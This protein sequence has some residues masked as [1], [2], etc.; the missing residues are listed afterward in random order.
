VCFDWCVRRVAVVQKYRANQKISLFFHF[1]MQ[2]A[3]TPTSVPPSKTSSS[4]FERLKRTTV[5]APK[6]SKPPKITGVL[7]YI[8]AYCIQYLVQDV[9][10]DSKKMLVQIVDL[11]KLIVDLI[12]NNLKDFVEID[13]HG[14]PSG[15]FVPRYMVISKD[16]KTPVSGSCD[17]IREGS[18]FVIQISKDFQ[19]NVL[20][21][22]AFRI[23]NVRSEGTDLKGYFLKGGTASPYK[24][25]EKS[26]SLGF[27]CLIPRGV[28]ICARKA[29][30][31]MIDAYNSMK[32]HQ[33]YACVESGK[34]AVVY[35]PADNISIVNGDGSS[36]TSS[37]PGILQYA[38][39]GLKDIADPDYPLLKITSLQ[40]PLKQTD[41]EKKKNEEVKYVSCI[42]GKLL[43]CEPSS[44]PEEQDVEFIADC[45]VSFFEGCDIKTDKSHSKGNTTT[46]Q[47]WGITHRR[48][49]RAIAQLNPVD[50]IC[51]IKKGKDQQRGSQME[52]DPESGKI[53]VTQEFGTPYGVVWGNLIGYIQQCGLVVRSSFANGLMKH[54][55]NDLEILM[56]KGDESKFS[57]LDLT[58]KPHV[59]GVFDNRDTTVK[60]GK[61]MCP[62]NPL[63]IDPDSSVIN[64]QEALEDTEAAINNPRI[65]VAYLFGPAKAI[66][67]DTFAQL[68]IKIFGK[69]YS[70]LDRFRINHEYL[71]KQVEDVNL[72]NEIYCYNE[73][74]FIHFFMQAFNDN[75]L[76]NFATSHGTRKKEY[77]TKLNDML[78]KMRAEL[79]AHK[80]EEISLEWDDQ[81]AWMTDFECVPYYYV[82][83]TT[84]VKRANVVEE[85]KTE[86]SASN[87]T[88][89]MD[90]ELDAKQAEKKK[91][92]E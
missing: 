86:V 44:D 37:L 26:H 16:T 59:S 54:M 3:N 42:R 71:V 79:L 89:T 63:N 75:P 4:A 90:V 13:K 39:H 12:E 6:F 24:P 28:D 91:K 47:V 22:D 2:D 21:G 17:V 73:A 32:T 43:S 81:H 53:S 27:K 48:K 25:D 60:D 83:P 33:I 20:T 51:A 50:L 52:E 80:K 72:L 10:F 7:K 38:Y 30:S 40:F 9:P 88:D 58:K 70:I 14:N 64:I 76:K 62:L 36:R 55:M 65:R 66:S 57:G 5:T 1:E 49:N 8:T 23:E 11:K 41:E 85:T 34:D 74:I 67:T 78:K 35:V 82:K 31:F 68:D 92:T 46:R 84:G 56:N 18:V 19:G 15:V 45:E 69:D 77:K 61:D 87:G 29:R